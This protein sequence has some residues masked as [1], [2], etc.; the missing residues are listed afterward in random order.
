S[1]EQQYAQA[2][3]TVTQTNKQITDLNDQI[4]K[5]PAGPSAKRTD[6]QKQLDAANK[7]LA[8][9]Q[10]KATDLGNQASV[11]NQD[12]IPV[13]KQGFTQSQIGNDS[14]TWLQDDELIREWLT[15]Q[16]TAIQAKIN[17]SAKQVN[18]DFNSLKAN[19]PK[20]N[21]YNTFMSQMGI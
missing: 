17:P 21:G 2:S 16:S 13:E 10:K 5:L 14:A 9:E 1:V 18:S 20:S 11:L 7:T 19:M 4:K 3:S 8:A 6:L 15:T 12:T